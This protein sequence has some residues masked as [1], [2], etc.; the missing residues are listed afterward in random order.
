MKASD[1]VVPAVLLAG[2]AY[3]LWKLRQVPGIVA[4]HH[5]AARAGVTQWAE[6]NQARNAAVGLPSD[7]GR[8]V[9]WKIAP[10]W[11]MTPRTP[12]AARRE[13]PA[14]PGGV[15][16]PARHG[17]PVGFETSPFLPDYLKRLS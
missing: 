17:A 15:N 7:G 11:D 3:L 12:A 4:D 1:V 9:D 5:D 13:T 6:Q 8:A 2:V 14:Y 16:Y 10:A